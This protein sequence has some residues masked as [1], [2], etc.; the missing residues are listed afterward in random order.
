MWWRGR[1]R[2]RSSRTL[3]N[4]RHRLPPLAW[5]SLLAA[6]NSPLCA[7]DLQVRVL[8]RILLLSLIEHNSD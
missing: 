5:C 7:V 4:R 8:S 6:L 3:A 2:G 1:M